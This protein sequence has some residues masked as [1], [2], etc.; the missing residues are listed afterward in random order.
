MFDALGRIPGM[1]TLKELAYFCSHH[2]GDSKHH[3]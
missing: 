2:L 3:G 1:N